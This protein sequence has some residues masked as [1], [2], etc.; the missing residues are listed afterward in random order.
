MTVN[1]RDGPCGV[2]ARPAVDRESGTGRDDVRV[3]R[4]GVGMV[5]TRRRTLARERTVSR[6]EAIL[7]LISPPSAVLFLV[8]ETGLSAYFI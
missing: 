5:W 2:I 1:G 7:S 4:E 3:R 8:L 6:D